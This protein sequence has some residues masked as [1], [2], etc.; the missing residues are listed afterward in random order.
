MEIDTS[1]DIDLD[2]PKLLLLDQLFI[3]FLVKVA[4]IEWI[5]PERAD[6]W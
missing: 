3:A 1:S 6:V 2:L 4:Y 5:S